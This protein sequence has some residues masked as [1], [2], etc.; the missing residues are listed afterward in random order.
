MTSIATEVDVVELA[1]HLSSRIPKLAHEARSTG[2][3]TEAVYKAFVEYKKDG[4]GPRVAC[5]SQ[6]W[7]SWGEHEKKLE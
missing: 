4:Y 5:E 1:H 3:W 6:W 2:H 7:H